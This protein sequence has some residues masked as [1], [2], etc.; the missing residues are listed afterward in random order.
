MKLASGLRST[1]ISRPSFNPVTTVHLLS[2]VASADGGPVDRRRFLF[3]SP[4]PPKAAAAFDQ[5]AGKPVRVWAHRICASGNGDHQ[6][7]RLLGLSARACLCEVGQKAQAPPV[8]GATWSR[9]AFIFSPVSVFVPPAHSSRNLQ[10]CNRSVV[11]AT[12]SNPARCRSDRCIGRSIFGPAAWQSCDLR[13]V[14]WC[15][16]SSSLQILDP[17]L[18]CHTC[19]MVR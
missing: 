10:H 16:P 5:A 11:G 18:R 13:C 12:S 2:F 19:A 1:A 6:Q 8:T 14:S 15:E 17:I 7:S 4:L 9:H 3:G